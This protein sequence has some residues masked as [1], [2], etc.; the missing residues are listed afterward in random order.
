MPAEPPE[1]LASEGPLLERLR[2][3]GDGRS[4]SADPQTLDWLSLGSH[5][6]C[7][8]HVWRTLAAATGGRAWL[9]GGRVVLVVA[10]R[11]AA[12]A[13]GTEYVVRTGDAGDAL[14]LRPAHRWGAGWVTDISEEL[15]ADWR[16]GRWDAREVSL[17][18]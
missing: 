13:W 17:L 7:V 12:A 15:G 9:Y 3:H 2:A 6:D 4:D 11:I 5:P 14:G 18:A 10:G 16:F 8:E 1:L